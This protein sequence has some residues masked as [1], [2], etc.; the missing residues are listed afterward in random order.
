MQDLLTLTLEILAITTALMMF[1]DFCYGLRPLYCACATATEDKPEEA[2]P[3]V[4]H[5]QIAIEPTQGDPKE[6]APLSNPWEG[7]GDKAIS[8]PCCC[9]QEATPVVH[10]LAPAMP[11]VVEQF[12]MVDFSGWTIRALKKEA[13]RR[14]LSKYSSL[15]KA[16]LVATLTAV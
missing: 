12:E 1:A 7:E 8:Q 5:R 4:L 16:Q 14:K 9:Q 13:Q 10:L 6:T 2:I 15:T 11:E 3:K